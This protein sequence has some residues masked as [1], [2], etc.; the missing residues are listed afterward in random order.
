MKMNRINK[1]TTGIGWFLV[2]GLV[3]AMILLLV[4]LL[5]GT[6]VA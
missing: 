4:M 6:C 2:V 1:I 3:L 5:S